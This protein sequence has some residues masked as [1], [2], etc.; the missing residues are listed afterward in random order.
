MRE[1]TDGRPGEGVMRFSDRYSV[2][3][4]GVL[5]D[6][7][8]GKGAAS[9]AMAVR[10]F[11]L[12]EAAGVRTHFLEQVADD[13]IRIRLLDV[14]TD[15]TKGRTGPG[16]TI[17]LQVIYRLALPKESSVHRRAR[18][19]T[20]DHATVPAYADAGAPWLS[21]PMVEFTT[22]Y[23]ETDRFISRAEAERVGAVDAADIAAVAE[24]AERVAGVVDR[25]CAEVGLTLV[26]GKAEF[27]YDAD[28]EPILIDHAG[29]PD[30]NRFYLGGVPVCKELLRYLHP[31]L[32]EVVQRLVADGVPRAQW[33]AQPPLPAES[34]AAT[35]EVYAR[36]AEVWTG[37]DLDRLHEAVRRF[38][39]AAGSDL[40]DRT[41]L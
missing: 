6:E 1:P 15:G 20:L 30:E 3:D 16:R 21:R 2:F 37:G 26:D 11:E 32:R 23:E 13:A 7:V 14:D 39:A 4:F 19:G 17:P 38:Q 27:G 22:K 40:D 18:A 8:P 9:C 35:A 36:L 29:T 5:P 33:P 41:G 34:V 31:G 24:L 10:S 25:H 12:F 28:R